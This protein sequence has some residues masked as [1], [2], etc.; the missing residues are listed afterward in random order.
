M[1]E[2]KRIFNA[3]KMNR[4]L[5]DRLV[6]PGEYRDAL[7]VGIGRSE[8]SDVGAV[9]NLKGNELISGQDAIQG[10]TI[11][12]VRDPNTNRIYWM[13]KGDTVDAIYEFDGTNIR[14]I[15]KDAVSR[16][17]VEGRPSCQPNLTTGITPPVPDD[18]I[19]PDQLPLPPQPVGGCTDGS[20]TNFDPG[21]DFD[22]GSC[23]FAPPDP[24]FGFANTGVTCTTIP[25]TGSTD[26]LAS[27]IFS[28]TV[29]TITAITP[30]NV[31][32][33]TGAGASLSFNVSVTVAQVPTGFSNSGETNQVFTGTVM[34]FQEGTTATP[35]FTFTGSAAGNITNVTISGGATI[36][37]RQGIDQA[38]NYNVMAQPNS[39]FVWATLPTANTTGLPTGVTAGSVVGTVGSNVAARVTISGTWSPTQDETVVTTF[40][41]GSVNAAPALTA[42][43]Q[44]S[45][46][47]P[48]A[49][50][51]F[52]YHARVS[53][54]TAPYT[55]SISAPSNT[56]I[57][58]Q[59]PTIVTSG[60]VNMSTFMLTDGTT[61]F[62]RT[63]VSFHTADGAIGEGPFAAAGD[64]I[65]EFN[66]TGGTA[67]ATIT[68]M[69][70]AGA[71]DTATY[72]F[73][74]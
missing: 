62:T 5:D 59:Q 61:P 7:N 43:D 42:D 18:N 11:G 39:G 68:V 28:A 22:D 60:L 44:S 24:A 53:G 74:N 45:R 66:N 15:L 20:A 40:N 54:G 46:V 9:E 56:A 6:P 2:S 50:G 12:V 16:S 31:A 3:G 41:G 51:F 26:L 19:R 10:T 57:F 23:Q 29:G 37:G 65:W 47:A 72:T 58:A 30:N 27:G 34:C 13:T 67:T 48:G 33:R 8:G 36:T 21:A 70:S 25:Q 73:N 52:H 38:V 64:V 32:A 35:E 71:S 63:G 17:A 69:D 49:L 55:Y 4:D 14:P 1:A